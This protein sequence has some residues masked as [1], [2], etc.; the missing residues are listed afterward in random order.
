[1]KSLFIRTRVWKRFSNNSFFWLNEMTHVFVYVLSPK[2]AKGNLNMFQNDVLVMTFTLSMSKKS[3]FFAKHLVTLNFFTEVEV[4]KT[5]KVFLRSF[6]FLHYSVILR[7]ILTSVLLSQSTRFFWFF[8][9]IWRRSW[10]KKNNDYI[11]IVI[12][13]SLHMKI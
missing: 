5:L 3:I 13:F 9:N 7:K 6:W 12:K 10:K 4:K 2:L 11:L 1:M 8:S